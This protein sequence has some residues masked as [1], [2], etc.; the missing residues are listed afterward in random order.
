M[1]IFSKIKESLFKT[2]NNLTNKLNSI[3]DSEELISNSFYDSLEEI[4][5]LS[6][7]GF[8]TTSKIITKLKEVV[9]QKKIKQTSNAKLE[10]EQIVNSIFKPTENLIKSGSPG[11][12]LLVGING[13]G[14]TTTIAKLANFL[15]QRN[16]SVLIAA[17]DT[18]R[19][20]AVNQLKSLA[21]RINCETFSNNSSK[22]PASIVYSAI[23]IA[24]QKK[25]DFV[26][27]DT[28]GRLHT[29]SNLMDELS[30]IERVAGKE[31]DENSI[32]ILLVLDSTTGQNGLNQAKEFSKRV[33]LTGIVL[34]KL[35]GTSKG[36]IVLS[37]SDELNQPIKF[38][39]TGETME[40]FHEFNSSVFTK[41]LLSN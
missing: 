28:A 4:L 27:A 25:I 14:K 13:V 33:N 11:L 15:M 40:N 5:I 2:R 9:K 21:E 17:A 32:E 38:I 8:K 7:V 1:S 22:D 39:G 29:N 35:D 36:G 18:F 30:K 6:D 16:N 19:A 12:I 24:K 34:T 41:A 20:A 37:I 26:L 31:I 10:L 23:K 3:V